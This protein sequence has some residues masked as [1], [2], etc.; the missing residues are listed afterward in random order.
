MRVPISKVGDVPQALVILAYVDG[1]R[2]SWV[3][4][5]GVMFVTQY[6]RLIKTVGLPNDLR[7]LGSLDK[8]PLKTSCR[9]DAIYGVV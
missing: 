2:M 5:D 9:Q 3:S 1:P 8:D 4:A 6:G 7:Y